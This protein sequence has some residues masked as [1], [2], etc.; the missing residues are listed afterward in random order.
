MTFVHSPSPR[1]TDLYYIWYPKQKSKSPSLSHIP[2]LNLQKRASFLN[3]IENYKRDS[4]RVVA[5]YLHHSTYAKKKILIF[6]RFFKMKLNVI[7]LALARILLQDAAIV[8][9]FVVGG[10]SSPSLSSSWINRRSGHRLS[11]AEESAATATPTKTYKLDG[12]TIAG[13]LCPCNNFILVKIAQAQEQTQGGILLAGKAKIKKTEGTVV[14]VGPGKTHADSGIV[15]P[16]PVAVGDGVVYGKYDGTELDYNGDKHTLIRD[17]DVLVKFKG[18][19]GEILSK[20]AVEVIGDNVLVYSDKS[21]SA[22]EGGILIAT[23]VSGS[24]SKPSTGTV[25]K[26]GPGR[27]ASN[28]QVMAMEV[29]VGDMVKFR[30]FA[31]NE[32]TIQDEEYCVVKMADILAKF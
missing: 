28:G 18:G 23:S 10:P 22:T 11:M 15:V 27:M 21:E 13:E 16:M 20:D 17:D 9:A 19:G 14:A 2:W 3:S 24:D 7:V 8:Q 25:I 32:V 1:P 12:R 4:G 30:D 5:S 6:V 26:V 29:Q 31:G